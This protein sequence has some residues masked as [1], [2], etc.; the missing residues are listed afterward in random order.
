MV[1]F[2]SMLSTI[3][4]SLKK[5]T[6]FGL[7][8][9]LVEFQRPKYDDYCVQQ[10]SIFNSCGEKAKTVLDVA[11]FY[12]KW[13]FKGRRRRGWQWVRWLECIIDPMDMSLN[14]LWEIVKDREAW[15]AAVHGVAKSLTWP[16]HWTT[17][18]NYPTAR[19]FKGHKR[20]GAGGNFI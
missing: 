2:I 1:D 19:N 13:V 20:L 10:S 11:S 8:S 14:K 18:F 6:W 12:S 15:C 3:S 5:I 4:Y 16:S 17:T 7:L 9:I